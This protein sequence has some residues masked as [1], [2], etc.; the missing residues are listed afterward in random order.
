M[1][2][3]DFLRSFLFVKLLFSQN[4]SV[5]TVMDTMVFPS[6]RSGQLSAF[7]DELLMS[8]PTLNKWAD[9]LIGICKQLTKRNMNNVLLSFQLFIKV[10]SSDKTPLDC[11]IA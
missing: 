4:V 2:H 5:E 3:G 6:L 7:E 8:D 11:L 10:N 9:Y 1:V